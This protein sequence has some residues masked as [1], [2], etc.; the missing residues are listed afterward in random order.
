[1]YTGTTHRLANGKGTTGTDY[2]M[3]VAGDYPRNIEFKSRNAAAFVE[4]IFRVSDKFMI[5]PGLRY[6]RLEGSASG[7]NGY[8][9]TGAE[10]AL[11]NIKRSPSFLLAD[12]GAE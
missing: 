12:A 4:N 5:I 1:M 3:T 11:Q 7:R 6:E 8:T 2:D 10:I 9:S